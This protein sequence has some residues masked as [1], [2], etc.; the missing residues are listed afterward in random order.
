MIRSSLQIALTT[1]FVSTIAYCQTVYSGKFPI[2]LAGC[3]ENGRNIIQIGDLFSDGRDC[4]IIALSDSLKIFRFDSNVWKEIAGF[5]YSHYRG[6][7]VEVSH[8]S[9]N[10]DWT[11]ADSDGD[12]KDEI[13]KF[14]EGTVRIIRWDGK[15]FKQQTVPFPAIVEQVI[16]GDIDNDRVDELITLSFNGKIVEPPEYR[17]NYFNLSI[18]EFEKG[19]F[20]KKWSDNSEFKLGFN[21]IIP[22]DFLQCVGDPDNKGRNLLITSTPQS[23]MSATDYVFFEWDGGK[24]A[25]ILNRRFIYPDMGKYDSGPSQRKPG[26]KIR[27]PEARKKAAA[28]RHK[29]QFG[30][31]PSKRLEEFLCGGIEIVSFN[32]QKMM[33]GYVFGNQETMGVSLISMPAGLESV[34]W[35]VERRFESGLITSHWMN[36]DGKGYGCLSYNIWQNKYTFER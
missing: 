31:Q 6:K 28:E 35:F 33:L 2:D 3:Q 7:L 14:D 11:V 27:S 30:K 22:P 29:P 32:D 19:G 23:D 36:P 18:W 12:G 13:F 24:L 1:I 4:L 16:A 20:T 17:E 8:E 10:S 5:E 15:S 9:Y 26:K 25:K 34:D 21:F